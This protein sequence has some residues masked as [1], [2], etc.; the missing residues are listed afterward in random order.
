L[1]RSTLNRQLQAHPAYRGIE[2]LRRG[3]KTPHRNRYEACY[4]HEGW[5]L[6]AK[7]PFTVRFTALGR[8]PVHAFT[9]LDDHSRFALAGYLAHAPSTAAAITVFETAGARW[10]LADR[11]QFDQGSAF[12]STAFRQ[13][14]AQLGIH[15]NAV[16]PR[17]PQ[18]QGKIEAYHRSL[19]RWFVSELHAQVVVDL[20]HLQQLFD[21]W[22]ALVYNRHHHRELATTPDK[23]L[24]GRLS[25]RRVSR[26]VLRRAFFVETIAKTHPKTGEVRLPNGRFRVPDPYAGQ[27]HRFAYHPVHPHALLLTREGREL[28]L[29]PFTV[30]PLSA[31]K[32]QAPKH[33]P[34]QLQKL[35]DRFAERP[36]AEPGF[37]LPEVFAALGKLVE[38]SLPQ[39]EREAHAVAAFYR[40]HGPLSREAFTAACARTHA[41]LG[42]GRALSAYLQ[43]LTRQIQADAE[44]APSTNDP[45]D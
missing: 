35:L 4:P 32:P 21:A 24:A 42:P 34:G 15:R 1:S 10:G 3:D 5:Q 11:F 37:G 22:L 30:K 13:G 43:D 20:D 2:R 16:K 45:T 23:R 29:E 9:V 25:D 26:S 17:T 12:E 18:W 33:G 41:A 31:V 39:S 8:Q 38:R 44:S 27:R 19:N 36:L 28:L 6:D 7:G 40:N 14:L